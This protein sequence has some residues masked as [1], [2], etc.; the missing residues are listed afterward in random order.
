MSRS[1]QAPD[2]APNPTASTSPTAYVHQPSPPSNVDVDPTFYTWSNTFSILLSRMTGNRDIPLETSYFAAQDS[3]KAESFC[4]RCESNR[5]YLLQYSPII[6]FLRGEVGKLGGDLNARN[7]HCRMCTAEQSGGFHV[8][9]GIML[10]ANKFRNRGHLEDTLAH[11]MVHAWDHLKFKVENGNLRHQACLEVCIWCLIVGCKRT[12]LTRLLLDTSLHP[13]RRMSVYARILHQE[14]VAHHR[15]TPTLRAAARYTEHD[16]T[17]RRQ[18][19]RPG[20]EDSKRG[21][22]QLLQ[23]HTT[24]RRDIPMIP[25]TDRGCKYYL[26]NI[27]D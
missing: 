1:E 16:G 22:G 20:C 11:E 2:G 6:T 4:K 19:R 5:D 3:I 17:T 25:E 18:R 12:L 10:C 27:V 9:H 8:D 7:V 26:Y 23:R 21:L 13:L 24:V 14:P 15:T